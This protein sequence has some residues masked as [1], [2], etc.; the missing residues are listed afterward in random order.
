MD[1]YR[2]LETVEAVQYAGEA[3][4][5]VTCEGSDPEFR[6]NGCD[7][8]RRFVRH[9]HTSEVGGMTVLKPGDWI[10]P[11]SGGPYRVVADAEFRSVVE[12]PKAKG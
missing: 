11:V 6:L 5:D 3:I 1:K 7:S 9:V 2:L 8:S 10:L 4:P 12:V